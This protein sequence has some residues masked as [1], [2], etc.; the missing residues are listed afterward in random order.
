ELYKIRSMKKSQTLEHGILQPNAVEL[1]EAVLGAILLSKD[2]IVL[3]ADI[4]SIESFY[5]ETNQKI[6]KAALELYNQ[7]KNIDLLTIVEQLKKN[8]DLEN[9]GGAYALSQLTNKIA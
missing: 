4:L 6:Y 3:V 9:V 1:E 2:A 8:G 5:K 7:S